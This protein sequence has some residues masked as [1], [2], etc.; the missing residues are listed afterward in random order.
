MSYSYYEMIEKLEELIALETAN[1]NRLFVLGLCIF[2]VI[3]FSI[4]RRKEHI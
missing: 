3:L 1:G 4:F 2:V